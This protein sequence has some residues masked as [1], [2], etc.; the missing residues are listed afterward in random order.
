VMVYTP[1]GDNIK[2]LLDNGPFDHERGR[3][4]ILAIAM[5]VAKK[6][7]PSRVRAGALPSSHFDAK[8]RKH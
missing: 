1:D 6:Y 3:N 5:M 2:L 4:L 7:A 8:L